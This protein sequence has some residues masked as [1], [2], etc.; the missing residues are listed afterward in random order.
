MLILV[1]PF[2]YLF[3]GEIAQIPFSSVIRD[4]SR[5]LVLTNLGFSIGLAIILS[6]IKNKRLLFCFSGLLILTSFPYI[7]GKLYAFGPLDN[8]ISSYTGK[9][10]RLRLL[11]VP[12]KN[13]EDLLVAHSNELNLFFPNGGTVQTKTDKRYKAD[14]WAI[15]DTE[16]SFSPYSAGIYISDKSNPLVANFAQ[17]LKKTE[18]N[19]Q[20]TKKF[21]GLYGV[22]NIINRSNLNEYINLSDKLSLEKSCFHPKN[23]DSDWITTD[24]CTLEDAYPLVYGSVKPVYSSDSILNILDKPKVPNLLT[25]IGCTETLRMTG[26]ECS[27]TSPHVLANDTPQIEIISINSTWLVVNATIIKGNFILVLNQTFHPGWRILDSKGNRLGFEH[28]LINQLVNGWVVKPNSME[29]SAQYTIEFYPQ[30]IYSRIFPFSIAF[31]VLLSIYLL[32]GWVRKK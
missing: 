12:M 20:L 3:R 1:A 6:S 26:K 16:S 23:G 5:F 9:N 19:F 28:I 13:N 32:T 4:S 30:K 2:I 15:S 25:V 21:V 29:T 18:T 14:F 24:I 17:T 11:D 22:N 31:F 27:P 8:G 10:F 7:S